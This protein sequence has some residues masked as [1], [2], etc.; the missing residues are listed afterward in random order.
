[1]NVGGHLFKT[2]LETLKKEESMLSRMFSGSGFKVEK[3]EDGHYF[4]DRPGVHF[5][6]ILDYLRTGTIVPP[7][8]PLKRAALIQEVDFY[9]IASLLKILT[10]KELTFAS[11][12]DTNGLLYW[13][14]T[15]KGKGPY[16]N[17]SQTQFVAISN[18]S[19][20][21]YAVATPASNT[22]DACGCHSWLNN[23]FEVSFSDLLIVPSSYSL[24]YA[25]S[26]GCHR[27]H[28]WKIEGLNN[29]KQ[30]VALKVHSND[31]ALQSVDRANWN[32]NCSERM[33]SFKIT[34]TGCDQ[35]GSSCYCFHVC[36]FEVYGSVCEN[37]PQ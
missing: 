33:S 3:D 6:S 10:I 14:G 15:E 8:N 31:I 2:S 4:I 26:S 37:E 30:W 20:K 16:K 11:V 13:L 12:N 23:Y 28:N 21:A 24:S 25:T 1:M 22:D 17:P 32:I 5:G 29:K 34:C 27:P 18:A 35:G 19:T 36:N 7:S 9:Q